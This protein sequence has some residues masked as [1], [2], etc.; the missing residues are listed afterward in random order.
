MELHIIIGLG[1]HA[2]CRCFLRDQTHACIQASL[3]HRRVR[4]WDLQNGRLTHTPLPANI[5]L[6]L[7]VKEQFLCILADLLWCD[8]TD[9]SQFK[10]LMTFLA[11]RKPLSQAQICMHCSTYCG[12]YAVRH[13][14]NCVPITSLNVLHESGTGILEQ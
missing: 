2:T 14:L 1:S 6:G 5:I 7:P 11:Q 13:N 9:N 12:T 8:L 10:R 3:G 4:M